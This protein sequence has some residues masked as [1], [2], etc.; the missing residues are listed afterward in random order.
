[1]SDKIQQKEKERTIMK[2]VWAICLTAALT[3]GL[4]AGCGGAKTSDTAGESVS[5]ETPAGEE[6]KDGDLSVL[7]LVPF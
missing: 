5:T 4:L 2:K 6:K 7:L 1:M 3:A